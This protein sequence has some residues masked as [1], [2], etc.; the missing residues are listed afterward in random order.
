VAVVGAVVV[1][2]QLVVIETRRLRVSCGMAAFVVMMALFGAAPAI[3]ATLLAMLLDAARRRV[4]PAILLL[5]LA[6]AAALGAAGGL[7][8]EAVG[9]RHDPLLTGGLVAGVYMALAVLNFGL[10][11]TLGA[12]ER[13]E[14][15]RED[16]AATFVPFIPWDLTSALIA[17]ATVVAYGQAGLGAIAVFLGSVAASAPLLRSAAVAAADER[18]EEVARLASD[19]ERLLREVLDVADQERRRLAETLHDGALQGLLA[20]RQDLAERDD[21][22]IARVEAVLRQTR[23][24]VAAFH[25]LTSTEQGLEATVRAAAE[26]FL[27]DRVALEVSVDSERSADPLLCSLARELVTNAVKH[28]RPSRV[29]VSVVDVGDI[30]ALEVVDDGR[31][32]DSSQAA[33]AVQAGHVGLAVARRRVEDAGGTLEIRTVPTGG[34]FVRTT[35]PR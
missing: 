15:L 28:A 11:A 20:L 23:A 4:R 22:A 7:A 21:P 1:L 12:V 35:L 30:V 8:F 27:R 33:A 19:R 25:P 18:A 13:A 10:M 14:P 6:S 3:A 29:R 32:I 16:F 17:G 2:S 26:P 31:G 34:T 24:V 9:L 5:N